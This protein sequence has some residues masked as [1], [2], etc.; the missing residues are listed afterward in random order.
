MCAPGVG[1]LIT[2]YSQ[3]VVTARD[4][5]SSLFILLSCATISDS[6]CS[7]WNGTS[8]HETLD[9]R[10]DVTP[11]STVMKH[12]RS[13]PPLSAWVGHSASPSVR[14]GPQAGIPGNQDCENGM[15]L[16]DRAMDRASRK[17]Y[18]HQRETPSI[19]VGLIKCLL[20][21]PVATTK[22]SSRTRK[23]WR[24]TPPNFSGDAMSTKVDDRDKTSASV[25]VP[26]Q[27]G[28]QLPD[29]KSFV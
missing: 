26:P 24:T 12:C 18:R 13:L 8:R 4:A 21:Q 1:Y 23:S 27:C 29:D 6:D 7:E 2:P 9:P 10:F 14:G 22:S 15:S 3:R 17:N 19:H 20:E 16:R 25:T 28:D 5:R 11:F